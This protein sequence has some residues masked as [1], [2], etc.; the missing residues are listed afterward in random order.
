MRSQLSGPYWTYERAYHSGRRQSAERALW[1]PLQP[2]RGTANSC[3][4]CSAAPIGGNGKQDQTLTEIRDILQR[5]SD[6]PT[7]GFWQVTIADIINFVMLLL[8]GGTLWTAR[9]QFHIAENQ[10]AIASNNLTYT[11]LLQLKRDSEQITD[12]LSVGAPALR[13][14]SALSCDIPAGSDQAKQAEKETNHVLDFYEFY[15]L[16]QNDYHLIKPSVWGQTCSGAPRP[17]ER[18]LLYQKESG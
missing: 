18:Q 15:Y 5:M 10:F 9:N 17:A 1:T 14:M 2:Q 16:A 4:R 3:A 8:I 11:L 13:R 12:F 6:R 7:Y